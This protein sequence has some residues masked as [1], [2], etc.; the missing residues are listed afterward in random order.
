M[1]VCFYTVA[2]LRYVSHVVSV[3]CEEMFEH[4]YLVVWITPASRLT[5]DGLN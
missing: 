4:F 5:E 2:D 1:R 3:A